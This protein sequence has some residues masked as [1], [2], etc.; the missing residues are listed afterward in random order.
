[1]AN[2]KTKTKY[3]FVTGGVVSGLGKGI[4]AASLGKILEARGF[5]VN[6]QKCDPYLNTDAGTLNPAEHG[7]VFVTADGAETDL[8]LGHYER[9]IDRELQRSSSTISGQIYS[10][11]IA[12]E[13][14]GMYLGKTVQIIPHV[15]SE[16]QR[17]IIDAGKKF[18]IHIVEIGGTVGDYEAMAFIESIRQMKRLVGEENVLYAHLVFLPFLQTSK[19]VKTKPAQNSVRDLREAGISP[20]V[21]FVRSDY[22]LSA[23][24]LDKMSLYCDVSKDAIVG[25]QTAETVYEVPLRM[26]ETGIADYICKQLHLPKRKAKLTE[27]S[28]LVGRIKSVENTVN[29]GVIAKYMNHED[30]YMSIF[31]ALRA[32]GWHHNVKVM[33]R[34]VNAEN[35]EYIEKELAEV[36][37][38]LVPGGFGS[39]GVEGKIAAAKYAREHNVPYLGICLGMQV[40][41]IEFARA[42]LKSKAVNSAE[43][44]ES[45]AHPV[46]HIMPDQVGV[47]MGGT[48]RLG[49]YPTKISKKS[50]AYLAYGTTNITERHRH[51][52]E[53]N[54]DYRKVLVD[55][56]MVLSGLSPDGNLVEIVELQNHPFYVGSQFHPEF[57]SRP[58]RAHPLFRDFIGAASHYNRNNAASKT[59]QHKTAA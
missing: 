32:A 50:R 44:D 37:G 48:M 16:I 51:R 27:W 25:L 40:A 59:I 11:V 1:M 14:K 35:T 58:N 29:I 2:K 47:E 57:K 42:V 45:I 3:I 17:R 21:L 43:F 26:E 46:V 8:D 9:F 38:I 22:P 4:T 52:F 15:T 13:R 18:D 54:N 33:I 5:L 34:W 7:E 28:N 31:E 24:S 23:E 6:M 12:N 41:V 55:N 10:Q 49:N 19:E 39:R 36:Q 53:F 56:G 20:N 30:T